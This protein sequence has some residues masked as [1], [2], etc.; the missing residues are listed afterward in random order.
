VIAAAGEPL[1]VVSFSAAGAPLPA[2]AAA[3]LARLVLRLLG[4]GRGSELRRG[5]HGVWHLLVPAAGAAEES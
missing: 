2:A 1:R 4:A 5:G 3:G